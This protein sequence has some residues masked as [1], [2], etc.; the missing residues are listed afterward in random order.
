MAEHMPR[1]EHTLDI[2]ADT[3]SVAAVEATMKGLEI[4][5]L[6]SGNQDYAMIQSKDKGRDWQG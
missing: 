1:I 5:V 2:K 6:E 4:P 3:A